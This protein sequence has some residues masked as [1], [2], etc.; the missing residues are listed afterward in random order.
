MLIKTIG[1]VKGTSF[2]YKNKHFLG[3]WGGFLYNKEETVHLLDLLYN[4]KTFKEFL[5][6]ELEEQTTATK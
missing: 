2:F 4:S 6:I 5:K 3:F 1:K